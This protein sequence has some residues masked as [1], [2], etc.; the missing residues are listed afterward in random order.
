MVYAVFTHMGKREKISIGV[1]IYPN[2]WNSKRQLAIISNLQTELDNN[3]NRI[4]NDRIKQVKQ[5]FTEQKCY[6]CDN[7]S[8]MHNLTEQLRVIINPKSRAAMRKKKPVATYAMLELI[9]DKKGSTAN[10]YMTT[11]S[12]FKKYLSSSNIDDTFINMNQLTIEGYKEFLCAEELSV[13]TINTRLTCI[14]GF[15]KSLSKSAK[16][17]YDYN[18]NRIDLVDKLSVNISHSQQN[19]KQVDLNEDEISTLYNLENLSKVREET[20]DL[21]VLQCWTGQRISDLCK[22]FNKE[23]NVS[24]DMVQFTSKKTE[25]DVIIRL[26][27]ED[28]GYDIHGI[29]N[30]YITTGFKCYEIDLLSKIIDSEE[31]DKADR[32]LKNVIARYNRHLKSI[33]K[34]AGLNRIINYKEQRGKKTID[35]SKPLYELVH[36]HTAR[37]S[38][39]T[40]MLRRGVEKDTIKITTGH[41][42]DQMIDKIYAHLNS[43]DKIKKLTKDVGSTD[44]ILPI[45][46]RTNTKVE[47]IEDNNCKY[48]RGADEARKVL[49]FLGV[50]PIE[51][52]DIEDFSEL[53]AMIGRQE[54][55]LMDKIG[56]DTIIPLKDIFNEKV[57]MRERVDKLKAL[58]DAIEGK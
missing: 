18:Q 26:N 38:Y 4:V 58:V 41:A 53:M 20:R 14:K 44:D 48:V 30:K 5:I 11:I 28:F 6:L 35:L 32:A 2:Q 27:R 25:V 47:I 55:R 29:I 31:Q 22:L 45:V 33:C 52:V 40:N 34:E 16:Y 10:A 7:P 3:N 23:F 1:K 13:R 39:V 9:K 54:G 17:N 56:V 50:N 43:D 8:K 51:W 37:H 57:S 19:K 42:D 15:L 12:S 21:F 36:S 46:K 24:S 49:T